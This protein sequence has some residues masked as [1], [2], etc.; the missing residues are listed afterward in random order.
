MGEFTRC[1]NCVK[2]LVEAPLEKKRNLM[3]CPFCES[4]Y[5]MSIPKKIISKFTLR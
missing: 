5:P 4:E 2:Q 3:V 1:P